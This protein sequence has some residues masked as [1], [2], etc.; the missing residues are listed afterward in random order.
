MKQML[1]L[2]L[3]SIALPAGAAAADA[4]TRT[5]VKGVEPFARCFAA[6]EARAAKPWSFVPKANGGGTFSD[7]GAAGVRQPYFLDLAD[8][9]TRREIRLTAADASV[10]RAVDQCL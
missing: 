1:L 5:T 10:L 2:G 7:A 8:R 4:P 3:V 9:G 6:A